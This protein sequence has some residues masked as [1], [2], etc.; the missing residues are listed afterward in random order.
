MIGRECGLND[1]KSRR[2][3][4][5]L[6]AWPS[7]LGSTAVESINEIT[8]NQPQLHHIVIQGTCL[9]EEGLGSRKDLSLI[10][11][12]WRN[13]AVGLKLGRSLKLRK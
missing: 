2:P 8:A 5:L 7:L 11:Q 6:G 9:S 13:G 1:F 12:T 3:P 4:L 10:M